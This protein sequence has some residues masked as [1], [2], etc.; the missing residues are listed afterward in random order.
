MPGSVSPEQLYDSASELRC[1]ARQLRQT[2]PDYQST[3]AAVLALDNSGT[4]TG[5]YSAQVSAQ[6]AGLQ[7]D[8][9]SGV[10]SLLDVADGWEDIASQ[11]EN[12]A[13]SANHDPA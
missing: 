10:Q 4:W 12:Q 11:M 7:H 1:C 8:L 5:S 3:L 9:G 13:A 6:I 2:I